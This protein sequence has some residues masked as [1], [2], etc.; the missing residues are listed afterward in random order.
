MSKGDEKC[1]GLAYIEYCSLLKIRS[2]GE[3]NLAGGGGG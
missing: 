2:C 3:I 1:H